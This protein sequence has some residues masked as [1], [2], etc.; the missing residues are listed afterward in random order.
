MA[1]ADPVYTGCQWKMLQQYYPPAGTVYYHF[2]KWS[3]STKLV[4]FLRSLVTEG[5]RR[6]GRNPRPTAAVIDGQSVRVECVKSNFG[7]AEFHPLSG[8]W[9]VERTNPWL[10]NHRRLC[11]NYERY[12]SP[13]RA[14]TYLAAILFMLRHF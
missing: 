4:G 3:Q 14:M 8:R 1:I 12:L 9:V 10:E 11:R 2:R 5:R 6:P 7:M 13:A